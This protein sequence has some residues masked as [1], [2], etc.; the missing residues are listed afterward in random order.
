M[1]KSWRN[2]KSEL[3]EVSNQV[4]IVSCDSDPLWSPAS[5][6][7]GREQEA[8]GNWKSTKGLRL[9][10]QKWTA[11]R[12]RKSWDESEPTA[13]VI[14]TCAT[15]A[16]QNLDAN[17][18]NTC[19]RIK[20]DGDN[21][22]K[23]D[24]SSHIEY[25]SSAKEHFR[26]TNHLFSFVF[27]WFLVTKRKKCFQCIHLTRSSKLTEI[28][29][30]QQGWWLLLSGF[31]FLESRLA[32]SPWQPPW[33]QHKKGGRGDLQNCSPPLL[34]SIAW[35]PVRGEAAAGASRVSW[36]ESVRFGASHSQTSSLTA[37]SLSVI[38]SVG[39]AAKASR[40]AHP[41]LICFPFALMKNG[42]ASTGGKSS[43]TDTHLRRNERLTTKSHFRCAALTELIRLF[44]NLG[45]RPTK[46]LLSQVWNCFW[47]REEADRLLNYSL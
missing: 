27:V 18:P 3:Q 6:V 41:V 28:S 26:S 40:K 4:L 21:D 38:L 33:L 10:T 45:G 30:Q 47:N 13:G 2:S 15:E 8:N 1:S 19:Q 29:G 16:Q 20:V 34:G 22:S 31:F 7:C 42:S 35:P 11:G 44:H 5:I 23:P 39:A 9:K 12:F 17:K 24:T 14:T 46:V 37:S 36:L 32:V 25:K 43:M